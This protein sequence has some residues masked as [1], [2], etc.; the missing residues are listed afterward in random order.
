MLLHEF[1][2]FKDFY[3]CILKVLKEYLC[4]FQDASYNDLTTTFTSE[5]YNSLAALVIS[6]F[7]GSLDISAA[8]TYSNVY[9]STLFDTYKENTF[10]VINGLNRAIILYQENQTQAQRI[11][12]LEEKEAILNDSE[13]LKAYLEEQRKSA[14]VLEAD[15]DYGIK[16]LLKPQYA[17]YFERHGFPTEGVFDSE[18]LAIIIKE[19]I[20]NGT[21]TEDD[22]F[23]NNMEH[24]PDVSGN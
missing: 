1:D 6:K 22:I 3:D 16:P 9:D 5:V 17:L 12:T 2:R 19:L 4:Y 14:V 24:C 21:L 8:L 7:G 23:I 20:D 10:K 11:L 15:A 18:K 13:L